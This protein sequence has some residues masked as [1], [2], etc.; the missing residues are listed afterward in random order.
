MDRGWSGSGSATPGGR[1]RPRG[2]PRPTACRRGGRGTA[3]RRRRRARARLPGQA[4]ARTS[5]Q[6]VP[7]E[8]QRNVV[9][10]AHRRATAVPAELR[11]RG[12]HELIL[13]DRLVAAPQRRERFPASAPACVRALAE[14]RQA[15]DHPV[16]KWNRNELYERGEWVRV[17]DGEDAVEGKKTRLASGVAARAGLG[18]ERA[19]PPS[20]A[21]S[22]SPGCAR[23]RR[24][25]RRC[26]RSSRPSQ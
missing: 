12:G 8:I 21:R 7:A 15:L 23:R 4:R 17:R 22:R 25:S 2:H 5:K 3:P 9:V 11:P 20:L 16:G 26:S 10:P 19:A 6:V 13:P 18:V 24:G 1:C 14:R